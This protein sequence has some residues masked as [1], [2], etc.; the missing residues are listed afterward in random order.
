MQ[1]A[2]ASFPVPAARYA[3][4]NPSYS[5]IPPG[6]RCQLLVTPMPNRDAPAGPRSRKV[7]GELASHVA[8]AAD[9]IVS[10]PQSR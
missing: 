8:R 3:P 6:P 7:P 9:G 5:R 1:S 10:T 2:L 4:S